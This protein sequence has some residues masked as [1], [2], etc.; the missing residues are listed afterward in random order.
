MDK[1]F[2]N[3]MKDKTSSKKAYIASFTLSLSFS[4]LRGNLVLAGLFLHQSKLN[5]HVQNWSS[6]WEHGRGVLQKKWFYSWGKNPWKI[7]VKEFIF[8][9]RFTDCKKAATG[10]VL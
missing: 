7:P 2:H 5:Y 1:Q 4:C 6:Q 10:D 9:Y 3:E 8:Q